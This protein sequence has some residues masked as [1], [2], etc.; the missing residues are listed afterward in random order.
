MN[1]IEYLSN[2][3]ASYPSESIKLLHLYFLNYTGDYFTIASEKERIRLILFN[4]IKLSSK[5]VSSIAFDII[6][7]LAERFKIFDYEEL[8]GS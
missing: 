6:N 1:F 2:Q 5:E 3:S 4:A 8:L 7:L